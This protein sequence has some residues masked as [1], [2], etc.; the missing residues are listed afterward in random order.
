MSKELI[1]NIDTMT[2]EV[3]VTKEP[4][5]VMICGG[6][7]KMIDLPAN[8]ETKVVMHQG[9]IKRHITQEGEEF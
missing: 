4:K 6:K 2:I 8:G 9:K 7:A 3:K 1:P 5:L